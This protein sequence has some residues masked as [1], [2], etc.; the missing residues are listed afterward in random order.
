M[1][2]LL[3]LSIVFLVCLSY[4][5]SFVSNGVCVLMICFFL[6]L[7]SC[8]NAVLFLLS[9]NQT[10]LLMMRTSFKLAEDIIQC[11][12]IFYVKILINN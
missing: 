2:H 3:L 4:D 9:L 10:F 12:F 11:I 5:V 6:L 7:Y 1:Q 8:L